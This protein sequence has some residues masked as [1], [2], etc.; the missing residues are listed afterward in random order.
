MGAREANLTPKAVALH[1]YVM[2]HP[3][4]LLTCDQLLDTV[5]G[6][7]HPAGTQTVDTRIAELRRVLS[8]NPADPQ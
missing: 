3:D 6:W 4:E 8:D 5:W 1:E 2:K 7:D